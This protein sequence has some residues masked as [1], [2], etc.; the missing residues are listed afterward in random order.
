[1]FWVYRVRWGYKLPK[2]GNFP[3][4]V[5]FTVTVGDALRTASKKDKKTNPKDKHNE[6]GATKS[7]TTMHLELCRDKNDG[8]TGGPT[9]D[10]WPISTPEGVL[11]TQ[12]E[13]YLPPCIAAVLV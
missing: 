7:N 8:R 12:H 2:T 5:A 11:L 9:H 4:K 10:V 1:V 3:F 6:L 13:G